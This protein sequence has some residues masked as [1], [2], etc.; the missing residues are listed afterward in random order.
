MDDSLFLSTV[1]RICERH[2][3]RIDWELSDMDLKILDIKCPDDESDVECALELE[4]V[5]GEFTI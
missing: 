2:G 4:S 1:S 5:M 3:C